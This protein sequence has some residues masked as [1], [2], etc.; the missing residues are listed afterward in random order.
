ML[1]RAVPLLF[2]LGCLSAAPLLAQEPVVPAAP[3]PGTVTPAG[4][5]LESGFATYRPALAQQAASR[6]PASAAAA[7]R[8]II[9]IS[10]LGLVLLIVLIV[11]LIA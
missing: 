1:R 3:A 5:R 9:T 2:A 11:I 10:T 4:P 7:D 6:A 8:T